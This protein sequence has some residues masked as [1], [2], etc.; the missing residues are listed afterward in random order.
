MNKINHSQLISLVNL[1][2]PH[3]NLGITDIEFFTT[4]NSSFSLNPRFPQI[5]FGIPFSLFG[6]LIFTGL[7]SPKN[8]AFYILSLFLI[9]GLVNLISIVLSLFQQPLYLITPKHLIIIIGNTVK[10]YNWGAFIKD[11]SL[12]SNNIRLK[13]HTRYGFE[14]VY[15]T[16]L[17]DPKLVFDLI[18]Q[19]FSSLTSPNNLDIS[20]NISDSINSIRSYPIINYIFFLII[21]VW[22]ILGGAIFVWA[23]VNSLIVS[24]QFSVLIVTLMG[25]FFFIMG[26]YFTQFSII[27]I[28]NSSYDLQLTQSGILVDGKHIK[29]FV[30]WNEITSISRIKYSFSNYQFWF[31]GSLEH[32]SRSPDSRDRIYVL[33]RINPGNIIKKI[34]R[35]IRNQ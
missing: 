32:F 2:L 17:E 10:N 15:L 4:P 12:R 25:L 7:I 9:F 31:R 24:V 29:R 23:G 27:N 20:T 1:R 8:F 3:L 18:K 34:K 21:G 30:F 35:Y 6:S 22:W 33:T 19:K 14:D 16:N 28:F 13:H 5:L 26:V 11:I